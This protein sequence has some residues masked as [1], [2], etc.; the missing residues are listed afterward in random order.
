MILIRR[1]FSLLTLLVAL[2]FHIIFLLA[3]SQN[4]GIVIIQ[5]MNNWLTS[6]V[7]LLIYLI[8]IRFPVL[9]LILE[10]LKHIFSILLVTL[11][12]LSNKLNNFLFQCHFYFHT[13][14]IQFDMNIVKINFM[15]MYLSRVAQD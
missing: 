13:N 2:I 1:M 11:V 14:S 8:L 10:K 3:Y 15:M 12:R 5:L 4:P 7:I 6:S 9:H